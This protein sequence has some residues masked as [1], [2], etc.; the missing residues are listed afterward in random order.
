[1]SGKLSSGQLVS[2]FVAKYP[3]AFVKHIVD[4]FQKCRSL[5]DNTKTQINLA[6]CQVECLASEAHSDRV[7]DVI[8]RDD[9][10]EGSE[11][12]DVSRA[13]RRL[14]SNL[15]HPSNKD[16][17]RVLRNSGA[18][19]EAIRQARELECSVCHNHKAPSSALPANTS[20]ATR[21]NE[22][23]GLDVKYLPG[24]KSNQKVPCINI[25]DYA[26]SLQV[27][28]PIFQRETAEI[29]KGVLR[30]SWIHW[31]GIPE[32]L[33]LDPS[34]PNLSTMLAEYCESRGIVMHHIAADAHWQLGKVE[35]HGQ[36]FQSIFKKVC[37]EHPPMS[38]EDFVDRVSQ[39]Q[40]AKNSLISE[41]GASPFQHVFGRN[42]SI[43][44][45]VFASRES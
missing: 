35:R 16:L 14:H 37:D 18:S 4:G 44:E 39:T 32:H 27:M 34:K 28:R 42:P 20:R 8:E 25:I 11:I 12:G 19:E 10:P 24:W 13:L 23:I 1:M 29:T 5:P 33:E 40:Q 22:K 38:A 6:E 43:P 30:D 3:P 26:T 31:A 45:D 41:R 7:E 17:V 21:F 15:G 2:D 9:N 36:W